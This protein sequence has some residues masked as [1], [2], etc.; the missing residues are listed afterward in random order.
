[1][2]RRDAWIIMA[3]T[4]ALGFTWTGVSDATLNLFFTRM[5]YGPQFVGVAMAVAGLGYAVAAL[6]AAAANRR[7]GARRG[8]IVGALGWIASIVALSMADLVPITWRQPWILAARLLSV[9]A[10]ALNFVSSL[11]LLTEVTSP[12]ERPHAFALF[13]SLRPLGAFLGSLVGGLL[14]ALIAR[15]LGLSLGQ[16]R[17]YGYT[18]IIGLLAYVPVVWALTALRGG[19]PLERSGVSTADRSAVPYA[20]LAVIALVSLLRVGGEFT[21]RTFFNVY[22]DSVLFASVAHIGAAMALASLLTIPAPLVT[23]VCVKRFGRVATIVVSALGVSTGIVLLGLSN[24][25]TVAS[26]AFVS[27]GALGAMARSVWTLLTQESVEPEWRA[28][29]AAITNLASGLGVAAMSAWGGYLAAELGYGSMFLVGS[30]LVALGAL[31]CWLYF[32]VLRK[33]AADARGQHAAA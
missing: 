8:M 12:E 5:G 23:P 9:F 14:P 15:G 30:T 24:H 1:M 10:L 13:W 4:A 21:A 33:Q 19:Q 7:W 22:M 31:L 25:W 6:P 27:I 11:P 29:T 3:N 18:L 16:P 32:G 20:A 2:I 17:P 28:T 26:V